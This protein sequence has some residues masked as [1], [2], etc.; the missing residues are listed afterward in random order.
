[1]EIQLK[2]SGTIF[3]SLGKQLDNEIYT[4]K[5]VLYRILDVILFLSERGLPFRGVTHKVGDPNNGNFLGVL[6]LIS[7]YDPVLAKHLEQVKQSHETSKR[8]QVHYLSWETQNEFVLCCADHVRKII[9]H[10]VSKAKYYSIIVDATPDS[11]H[12]EQTSFVL[13]YISHNEASDEYDVCERFLE[14]ADCNEKTGQDIAHL[15]KNILEKYNIPLANCRGQGYDNGSNMSGAYKGVQAIILKWNP[16]ALY[17]PCACHSLNLCGVCAAEC[18]SEAQTFF[19]IVQQLYNLFSCSPKRWAILKEIVGFS[20]HS[21]SDTRWSARVECVRPLAAHIGKITEAVTSLLQL[22][23]TVE[24]RATINGILK[25]LKSFQCVVMASIWVKVLIPINYRSQLLQSMDAT[26]DVEISNIENLIDDLKTLRNKWNNILSEAELVATAN[27]IVPEFPENRV[28]KMKTFHGETPSEEKHSP[29]DKFRIEVFYKII[30][31][32]IFNLTSRFS[33]L[34]EINNKFSFLWKYHD[35]EETAIVEDCTKFVGEYQGDVSEELI[36][37][38]KYLKSI[39]K[40]NISEKQL[41][42][43]ILLNKLV[44]LKV[45]NLFPNVC[46]ALRMFCCL[47]VSVAQAERSFSVLSRIKNCYRS[48]MGQQRLSD[49]ALLSIE[50]K[51]ARTL[52]FDPIIQSFAEKKARKVS[53]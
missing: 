9:L 31:I 5:Q 15:I 7:H 45:T 34:K 40:V 33:A 20:L 24:T 29:E 23:I 37:E 27:D 41:Q 12:V 1:L 47:P 51:L 2:K 6:E 43:I 30:D 39:S 3:Q 25:Y 22:N 17:S 53:L 13:R 49:L 4:W 42:P 50:C 14:F 8:L 10:E 38:M 28:R 26:L 11:S 35:M 19:G 36:E 44:A 18:C 16:F 46:V 32:L 21:L 52:D 48:T